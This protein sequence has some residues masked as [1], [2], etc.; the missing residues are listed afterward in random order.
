MNEW[1]RRRLAVATADF[2]FS[3]HAKM[4]PSRFR[5]PTPQYL[6]AK[7][8]CFVDG[9]H[10]VF[11]VCVRVYLALICAHSSPSSSFVRHSA[12]QRN[13][14]RAA[15]GRCIRG[16]LITSKRVG[17]IASPDPENRKNEMADGEKPQKTRRGNTFAPMMSLPRTVSLHIFISFSC[18]TLVL[19]LG[20]RLSPAI[21][22]ASRCV[23]PK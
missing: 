11:A 3:R 1:R 15:W 10:A 16:A 4:L 23:R 5:S 20:C 7:D 12:K 19:V 13:K 8:W 22:S 21:A 18:S 6:A 14:K 2:F 9:W 17:F